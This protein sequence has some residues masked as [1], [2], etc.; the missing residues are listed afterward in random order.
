MDI[1]V[2]VGVIGGG[3]GGI[4]AVYRAALSDS[5]S[6]LIEAES[7]L[8]G[9]STMS[10]V[11][12]WEPVAGGDGFSRLL[13]ER[14]RQMP[15]GCGIYSTRRHKWFMTGAMA[16]F[17][18]SEQC[19]VPTFG[20]DDTLKRDWDY[21][22]DWQLGRWNGV[23]FE[24]SA[25]HQCAMTMLQE[26]GA[27]VVLGNPVVNVVMS[28]DRRRIDAVFLQDG[29]R[30]GADVW[31]DNSGFLARAAGC[32]ILQ[33]AEA[34]DAF[35]EP[36]APETVMSLRLNGV[37]LLF[38]IAPRQTG[39]IDAL[40]PGI[41]SECWWSSQFPLMVAT[42]YP[43]GDFNCNM[44]PTM[45]GTEF[46]IRNKIDAYGECRRRVYA[47]WHYLQTE[48]PE[49]RSYRL[50]YMFP[51][52]G[53][54][55]SFRVRCHYVLNENDLLLGLAGQPHQD[56]ILVADHPMDNHGGTEIKRRTGLYGIP[57]R[58]L[59]PLGVDNLLLA[60]RIA[61]FSSIAGSSC[62]LARTM[63]RLGECAGYAAG[64][65]C[66]NRCMPGEINIAELKRISN[67]TQGEKL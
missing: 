11:N 58:C 53:V 41:P 6:I 18:G 28:A 4:A 8:G 14:M 44:L 32:E 67:T 46:A 27:K 64:M 33:G 66:H 65:A 25:L 50:K 13:Y 15:Q 52:L 10:G 3:S 22:V 17:P 47:Y 30:I 39:Q 55:E 19:I 40:P 62:R 26:V 48:W 31:I 43:N 21:N 35:N 56:M 59:L 23:I 20:Y 38:R 29:S 5:S 36:D 12:C 45:I 1:K 37:S 2:N 9:T 49:F 63:M 51:R 24:P 16:H 60:G 57:Y 34:K 54:R 42:E 61:G 7:Q